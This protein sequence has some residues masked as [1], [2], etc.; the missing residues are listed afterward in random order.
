MANARAE[1]A[2]AHL[3]ARA[4]EWEHY[5]LVAEL[6]A[7][8]RWLGS[9]PDDLQ[10][11]AYERLASQQLPSGAVVP[12]PAGAEVLAELAESGTGSIFPLVYHAT[13]V[14]ALADLP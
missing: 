3:L 14:T 1:T 10:A 8:L 2:A 4:L 12:I 13:L 11:G 5:D 6:L 7:A 9:S